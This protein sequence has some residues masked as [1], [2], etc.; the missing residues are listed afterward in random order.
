M[1]N[2]IAQS[3]VVGLIRL[4]QYVVSP[5]LGRCCRFEPTCSHYAV[6]AIQ[7]HGVLRGLIFAFIRLGKCQPFHSGGVDPIPGAR[8]LPGQCFNE[9]SC[10][11]EVSCQRRGAR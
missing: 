11:A 4:Y 2:G 10:S 5:W 1:S 7:S 8:W 3:T 6:Q 9:P